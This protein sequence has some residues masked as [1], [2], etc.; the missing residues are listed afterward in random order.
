M[1]AQ[2]SEEKSRFQYQRSLLIPFCF[3]LFQTFYFIDNFFVILFFFQLCAEKRC[4]T[5]GEECLLS[6]A[7]NVH[8]KGEK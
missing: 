1:I 7:R 4:E 3:A 8:R 2:L 5:R 6:D